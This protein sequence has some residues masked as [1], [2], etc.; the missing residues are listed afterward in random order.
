[1]LKS[2]QMEKLEQGN[3]R[4][5]EIL[6]LLKGLGKHFDEKDYIFQSHYN[7]YLEDPCAV[8]NVKDEDVNCE[9]YISYEDLKKV[10]EAERKKKELA[11]QAERGIFARGLKNMM[12]GSLERPLVAETELLIERPDWMA[13]QLDNLTNEQRKEMEAYEAQMQALEKSKTKRESQLEAELKTL[14]QSKLMLL[15]EFDAALMELKKEHKYTFWTVLKADLEIALLRK[16]NYEARLNG[17]HLDEAL[18]KELASVKDRVN[19]ISKN[20]ETLNGLVTRQ[21]EN[22]GKLVSEARQVDRSFFKEFPK[23]NP[24][25]NELMKWFKCLL[26]NLRDDLE[27]NPRPEGLSVS[28]WTQM[29]ELRRNR[30]LIEKKLETE[31]CTLSSMK[32]QMDSLVQDLSFLKIQTQEGVDK[33]DS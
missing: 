9:K 5:R 12:N 25:Q 20:I 32:N 2:K 15:E 11:S 28:S 18:M 10:Q 29:M 23:G 16:S 33:V 31:E 1:M 8:L 17:K 4:A 30:L 3:T 13:T 7:P 22:C 27:D 14:Q 24:S 26:E 19:K 6:E 21:K